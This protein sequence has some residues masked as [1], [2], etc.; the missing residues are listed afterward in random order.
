MRHLR[1]LVTL[2]EE[3]NFTR[4]AERLHLTQQAL[5]GQIRQLEARV[6][7]QLVERDS[8]RVELTNAGAALCEQARPLL[9]SAEQ[10]IAAARAAG[11]E[12]PQLILG[13][14]AALTRRMVAPAIELF[15]EQR[16]DVEITIHFADFL[17]CYGGLRDGA[18]DVAVLYGQLDDAGLDLRF[19]FDL[20]RGVALPAD[21]PLAE[22]R[23]LSIEDLLT[24]P[25][26]D[27]PI[28]DR[29]CRD[30]WICA[31]QRGGRPPRIGAT[32]RTLDGLLEAIG[33]GLGVAFTVEMAVEAL[34][35]SAGVVFRPVAGID[36]L[37]FW[38]AC[39]AGD[40]RPQVA[41]FMDAAVAAQRHAR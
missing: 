33:A 39:R 8:R 29:V 40:D 24:E 17:D 30:F 25:L 2:A 4:A 5:S 38:V 19:L 21:H 41:A 6:G 23:E 16:P 13:Y 34:G 3:L 11:D 12:Q 15:A 10:A 1:A 35:S 18:A 37:D 27:V 9:S 32:V 14:V 31:K 7:T 26:I 36:P 28:A 22:A 20:P